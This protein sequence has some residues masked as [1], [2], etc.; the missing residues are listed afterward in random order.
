MTRQ[1]SLKTLKKLN[2]KD[3]WQQDELLKGDDA[4]AVGRAARRQDAV[5]LT[6]RKN[7]PSG[8]RDVTKVPSEKINRK[9]PEQSSTDT[10]SEPMMVPVPE[11]QPITNHQDKLTVGHDGNKKQKTGLRRYSCQLIVDTNTM[12]RN[13]KLSDN[14]RKVTC[15]REEQPHPDHPH[16]FDACLQ[17]LCSNGLTGRCYWEVEWKG[18]VEISVSYGGIGRRGNGDEC[19]FGFNA[20]SWILECSQYVDGYSVQHNSRRT[21]L[22]SSSVSGKAAVYV[23]CAAGTLSF[24]EVSSGKLIHLYTFSTTFSEPLYAGFGLLSPG[25]LVSLYA[26]Q[27]QEHTQ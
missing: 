23:D 18:W 13:L 9:D 5:D 22:S 2:I 4:I 19:R 27:E 12:N 17:L 26:G 7:E 25:S 20:Q 1:I 24:Y 15:V 14:N 11:P 16:R 10:R 6:V 3:W 8:A 21:E